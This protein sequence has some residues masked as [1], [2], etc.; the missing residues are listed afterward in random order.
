[1]GRGKRHQTEQSLAASGEL[2]VVSS[3]DE[4]D[5][6][7]LCCPECGNQGFQEVWSGWSETPVVV[8]IDGDIEA[9]DEPSYDSCDGSYLR[10]TPCFAEFG[11]DDL[12]TLA[13]W[14]ETTEMH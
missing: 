2:S 12:V 1:M 11:A 8:T 4:P 3:A 14:R 6:N 13:A 10:C 7:L 5:R 9:Q